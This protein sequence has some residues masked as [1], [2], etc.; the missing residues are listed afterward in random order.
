MIIWNLLVH[1]DA[2][3]IPSLNTKIEATF[4]IVTA[5]TD[6]CI[7]GVIDPNLAIGI[8]GHN[9]C[10][11]FKN[12][13]G[14]NF[15]ITNT[16]EDFYHT[17]HTVNVENGRSTVDGVGYSWAKITSYSTNKSIYLF[18]ANNFGPSKIKGYAFQIWNQ[19][20]LSRDFTPVHVPWHPKGTQNCM[21]DRVSKKLFC[22]LGGGVDFNIHGAYH[23]ETEECKSNIDC[24]VEDECTV[25]DPES[26]MCKDACKKI[27]YLRSTGNQY[28]D[29]NFMPNNNTS[30]ETN[31]EWTYLQNTELFGVRNSTSSMYELLAWN[32]YLVYQYASNEPTVSFAPYN[33][34]QHIYRT[35]K[36]KLYV[37]NIFDFLCFICKF[38]RHLA[39]YT[40]RFKQQWEYTAFFSSQDALF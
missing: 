21:F 6:D 27:E 29:T 31:A 40:F 19:E 4:R 2:D 30:I 18:K 23:P 16:D 14:S 33:N 17:L 7:M 34:V 5:G 13:V 3:F 35:E 37:D 28:I 20:K 11:A 10:G 8:G 26:K 1:N 9:I 36:N 25:C 32:N 22:N 38:H 15:S 24:F 39:S 12:G